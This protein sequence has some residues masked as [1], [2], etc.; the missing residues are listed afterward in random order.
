[1]SLS[2]AT[3][4]WDALRLRLLNVKYDHAT[5]L[6][7]LHRA[8]QAFEL[9]NFPKAW[10]YLEPLSIQ[11]ADKKVVLKWAIKIL[12]ALD[13][14]IDAKRLARR[15][16]QLGEPNCNTLDVVYGPFGES[17]ANIE[18]VIRSDVRCNRIESAVEKALRWRRLDLAG[19]LLIHLGQ[20]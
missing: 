11:Y 20:S 4:I 19:E 13:R 2:E 18:E 1:M 9:K 3:P 12:L 16:L 17:S 8:I 15:Y 7:N 6:L 5:P 14:D 10:S